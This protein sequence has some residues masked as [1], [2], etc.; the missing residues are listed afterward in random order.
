MYRLC[1]VV[2]VVSRAIILLPCRRALL[3]RRRGYYRAIWLRPP[4]NFLP[5][6]LFSTRCSSSHWFLSAL[7]TAFSFR[8]SYSMRQLLCAF[9]WRMV[10]CAP[11]RPMLCAPS[12]ALHISRA[13]TRWRRLTV[14]QTTMMEW[15]CHI[16]RVALG[17]P[18]H[19]CVAM[20]SLHLTAQQ[21]LFQLQELTASGWRRLLR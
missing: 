7:L 17:A 19:A 21:P 13:A 20:A 3:F 10:T 14:F 6:F 11:V 1:F 5:G 2:P 9:L 15:P 16:T 12:L 18:F 4:G 8:R